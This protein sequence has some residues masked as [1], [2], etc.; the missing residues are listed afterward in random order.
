M[1]D[2]LTLRWIACLNPSRLLPDRWM[3]PS[4]VFHLMGGVR[5]RVTA[6]LELDEPILPDPYSWATVNVTG[7][8]A[9]R[10]RMVR[11]RLSSVERSV[12]MPAIRATASQLRER[13]GVPVNLSLTPDR[14]SGGI[15]LDDD[16][17]AWI[18]QGDTSWRR[19]MDR[20]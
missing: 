2:A 18:K 5:F 8:R 10:A 16:M 9:R 6:E 19:W 4:H 13:Y 14:V 7:V 3:G 15:V 17:E 1:A 20:T 12:D 11:L